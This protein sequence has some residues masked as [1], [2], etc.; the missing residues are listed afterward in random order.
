MKLS[1]TLLPSI[2]LSSDIDGATGHLNGCIWPE[3]GT[4]GTKTTYADDPYAKF[5]G[6]VGV[7]LN[8][9]YAQGTEITRAC[10][11][12]CEFDGSNYVNCSGYEEDL[13]FRCG[14]KD[15]KNNRPPGRH[16][17]FQDGTTARQKNI[18]L[19]F[20]T[21]RMDKYRPVPEKKMCEKPTVVVRDPDS[22]CGPKPQI[23]NKC[24]IKDCGDRTFAAFTHW[25]T[26]GLSVACNANARPLREN[27]YEPL[28]LVCDR[29]KPTASF[30]W[31]HQSG[32]GKLRPAGNKWL[33]GRY[34]CRFC[35]SCKDE[36][37]SGDDQPEGSGGDSPD[38][39]E[40]SL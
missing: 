22:V 30:K 25:T 17:V 4:L 19:F 7:G 13:V 33:K 14:Y 6:V 11:T 40:V 20:R 3:K 12:F 15:G 2:V 24:D 31:F 26:N 5:D 37:T 16:Y 34:L 27:N 36:E 10:P 32:N 35:H 29:Q 38:N 1:I 18:A 9:P 39:A 28:N 23:P 21:P 8:A